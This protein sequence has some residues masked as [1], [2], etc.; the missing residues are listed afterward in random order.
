MSISSGPATLIVDS[1]P[2]M[3]QNNPPWN[4]SQ[5]NGLDV[6]DEIIEDEEE[7]ID[8]LASASEPEDDSLDSSGGSK[9]HRRVP[10]TTIMPAVKIENI[11]QAD[12]VTGSLSLSKEG[13]FVLSV[14][15]EEF[16]KR[17]VQGGHRQATTARRN[18]INYRDMADTT[19]QYQEFMFLKDIIP[20]PM[21]L[22]DALELR[23]AA[24]KDP[25]SDVPSPQAKLLSKSASVPLPLKASSSSSSKPKPPKQAVNGNGNNGVLLPP[26]EFKYD[27]STTSSFRV[28]NGNGNSEHLQVNGAHTHSHSAFAS[29]SST[30]TSNNRPGGGQLM[31]WDG[32]QGSGSSNVLDARPWTHWTEP[33]TV[34]SLR[35]SATATTSATAESHTAAAAAPEQRRDA[36]T[37]T[38]SASASASASPN[39]TTSPAPTQN[40]ESSASASASTN[41]PSQPQIQPSSFRRAYTGPAASGGGSATGFLQG[42]GN[43][44]GRTIYTQ[45]QDSPPP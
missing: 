21:S 33:I 5:K 30:S 40:S 1:T 20:Y 34:D 8:E 29:S 27:N 16:I 2:T 38:T 17:L 32:A 28:A 9:H 45:T 44:S 19:R 4:L 6:E 43:P 31:T 12:G 37:I 14:A 24:L 23:E 3:N 15:T 18:A 13:L 42:P 39:D 11:L 25:F 22:S 41:Q 35:H 10:G 7:E 36:I 26:R